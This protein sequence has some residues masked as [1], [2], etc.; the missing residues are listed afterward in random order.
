[1]IFLDVEEVVMQSDNDRFYQ[2]SVL[3]C[4]LMKISTKR[5]KDK[6]VKFIPVEK[7]YG[8][9]TIDAHFCCRHESCYLFCE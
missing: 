1:M 9:V 6:I 3:L 7:Q 5:C 8:K 4:G 2:N